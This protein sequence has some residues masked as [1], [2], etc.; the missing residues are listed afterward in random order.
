MPVEISTRRKATANARTAYLLDARAIIS[1]EASIYSIRGRFDFAQTG[2][3]DVFGV[4]AHSR[5]GEDL[6]ILLH[7]L[8]ELSEEYAETW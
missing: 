8:L 6:L 7:A 4:S 3:I 1:R 5:N 2:T